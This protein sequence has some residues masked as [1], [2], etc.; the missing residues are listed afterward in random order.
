LTITVAKQVWHYWR[1]N[2]GHEDGQ[3]H[4]IYNAT[5]HTENTPSPTLQ[6]AAATQRIEHSEVFQP[7]NCSQLWECRF[8]NGAETSRMKA[9]DGEGPAPGVNDFMSDGNLSRDSLRP[10]SAEGVIKSRL[11][12]REGFK[13]QSSTSIQ[14][15]THRI[16]VWER[17]NRLTRST[18]GKKPR[19]SFQVPSGK[20][21][22]PLKRSSPIACTDEV[23]N[24]HERPLCRESIV[25]SLVL[26]KAKSPRVERLEPG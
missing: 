11:Q 22:Q 26:Q 2:S 10:R 18:T 13:G 4:A 9:V 15:N 21:R 24:R 20:I 17:Q 8:R 7:L 14:N 5:N 25:A 23:T 1:T 3:S 6:F 16:L 12:D 19:P